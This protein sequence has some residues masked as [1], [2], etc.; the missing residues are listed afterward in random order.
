MTLCFPRTPQGWLSGPGAV[1]GMESGRTFR[2]PA[3][4]DLADLDMDDAEDDASLATRPRSP[5]TVVM[6]DRPE[7]GHARRDRGRTGGLSD[8]V[9]SFYFVAPE[10]LRGGHDAR[11]DLWSMG[12]ALYVM[13]TGAAP[14]DQEQDV[15]DMLNE[16]NRGRISFAGPDWRHVSHE[17]KAVVKGL[18]TTDA[19]RRMPMAEL[20]TH[21]W[22]AEQWEQLERERS[23]FDAHQANDAQ[24]GNAAIVG[25]QAV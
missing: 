16:I 25:P 14:F 22:L 5:A 18:L 2:K 7:N 23:I 8:R 1:H 6:S 11:C 21:P 10:V 15:E 17:A 9:G 24:S 13:L 19:N 20:R 3:A 4:G 12:V